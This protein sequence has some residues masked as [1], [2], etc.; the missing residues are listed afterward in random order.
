M[1][2]E[3]DQVKSARNLMKHGIS[4][5]NATRLWDD[6]HCIVIPA[7]NVDEIRFALIGQFQGILWTAIYTERNGL[8]RI[9]SVRHS[10]IEEKELY[11]GY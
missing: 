2:F 9:I 4:F 8:T 10:R 1:E 5:E 11:Y 7:K 6:S 3:F